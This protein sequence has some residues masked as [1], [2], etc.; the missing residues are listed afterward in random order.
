MKKNFKIFI[1]CISAFFLLLL[2]GL[3][4]GY[5]LLRGSLP[6]TTG[7]TAFPELSAPAVIERDALG[8][9][10]IYGITRIDVSRA[11]GFVHAQERFF[12]MD[13]M[14]RAAAGELSELFG[15]NAVEFD[16]KRRLHQLRPHCER[17]FKHLSPEERSSLQAY[18]EGVNRGIQ[19]LKARPFEYLFLM[20]EPSLWKPEDT[21]LVSFGLFF[22][23]QEDAGI[24]DLTR[25]YMKALLPGAVYN[26]FVNNGSAWDSALDGSK[27]SIL[28][29]PGPEHFHYLKSFDASNSKVS[30]SITD[31]VA[32]GGSNNWAMSGHRTPDGKAIIACDMHL[33]LA[34]PN[35]WYRASF[36]YR[37]KYGKEIKVSGA[38]LP[39]APIMVI[40]SNG[41][42]AW[43]FTNSFIDTTDLIII[44]TDP[45]DSNKYVTL[46]GSMPFVKVVET[47]NVK[48][49]DPIPFEITKTIWGPVSPETFFGDSLAIQWIAHREDSLNIR[50][51]ELEKARNARSALSMIKQIKIPLLNFIVADSKGNIGWTLAG[52]MPNRIGFDGTVPVSYADG[53]KRWQGIANPSDYPVLYNPPQQHIC[54]A[55]NRI[56]GS[57][58]TSVINQE[59]YS[60]SIRAYQIQRKLDNIPKA[61]PQNMLETQL[62][63]EALFFER[64]QHLLVD[65]LEKA[66]SS[67]KLTQLKETVKA[68]NKHSEVDSCGYYWIRR[69]REVTMQHV[70]ARFLSPCL[71]AWPKFSHTSRDFEE[72]LWI[73][74]S[75]K[76]DYLINPAFGSW[77]KELLSYVQM[78]LEADLPQV[79]SIKNAAW[80]SKTVLT[81]QH[82]FSKVIPS[83]SH[84]LD[85]PHQPIAGDAYMPK[86][87]GPREGASQRMVVSPGNEE[88]GIFH[89]PG[90]QSGHPLSIHYGDGHEAWVKGLPTPL[91]PGPTV[92]RLVLRP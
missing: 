90:G 70:L 3:F 27:R 38:T 16:K 63:T 47:I 32:L 49:A 34:M 44:K 25:G 78:M 37:D 20:T 1:Y 48:G 51:L 74:V 15:V 57:K 61:T 11:L 87:A 4:A 53:T 9:P 55:N 13:L 42:V 88:Q 41:S 36:N 28:P 56:I 73:L 72:P 21:L 14:R 45:H 84:F 26:F 5:F 35:I 92:E 40:G 39:G 64:W 46:K 77:D 80:G 76:P 22:E 85:M 91:L 59:G 17:L 7:E 83:L 52:A 24:P 12:Q 29:I 33:R 89:A 82:P 68:W 66:P 50:M 81:M 79:G 10:T 62:D 86:V 60:N 2:V 18:A 30:S 23:L 31:I 75:Q 69:F 67:E 6:Q 8:I 43:G 19:S 71:A 54:T 58:W 65:L